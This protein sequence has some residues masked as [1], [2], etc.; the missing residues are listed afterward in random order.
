MFELR[1]Q[2]F[3]IIGIVIIATALYRANAIQVDTSLGKILGTT[4]KS[5]LGAD[6]YA[7]RGI[8]YAQSPEGELRFQNPKPYP[9][10]KPAILDAIEDGPMC[11]QV[12]ENVT[13]MSEDC[14]RLNVYT[15]DLNAKKPVV[16]YLHPGGFYSVSAQSKN[17]AG[18]EN[19]MDRD[20]VLVTLNYRL[21][22]LGFLAVG[23]AEAPGNAGLKDQVE[24]LRWI[25]SHISHFGGDPN[26]VTLFGY[27]AGSFSIGLHMM[28]PMSK[29][30]FHRGIMMSAS[31]LGQF[32][33]ESRQKRLS[34]RQAELLN[35]P[36]EPASDL[37]KCLKK[38][39]MMDFVTTSA[40][41]FDFNWNPILN[42]LPV[43]E[44]DFGQERFLVE[45]PYKTIQS[46]NFQKVPIIIGITEY[47]FVERAYYLQLN[48]TTKKWLNEEF[49]MYAPI[50]LLYERDTA[51]SKS[52]SKTLRSTYLGN[53]TLELPNTLDSFGKLYSDG[54]I[55]FEYHRFLDLL[56]RVTTVY[57]YLFTYKGRYS[58]FTYNNEVYGA[59]HHDELLYL[60]HVPVKTP[61]FKKTDPEN[62]V[63][64]NLTRMW[65]QFARTGDPNNATDEYLKDIKWPAYTNDKKPYLVIGNDLDVKEGGIFSQRFQIWDE[66]FPVPKF[67]KCH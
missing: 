36:K 25:Q 5:R 4:L 21:G 24:A 19:F 41:M 1:M 50:I 65:S 44:E 38:K 17:F 55:G 2:F 37:V 8:R 28:S 27:S 35:C 20:I 49:E 23:S 64:E 9:P 51:R 29:G 42:W 48:E 10:W 59:V 11:P 15:K 66:L 52:I 33:Y 32:D 45:N 60:L 16:V 18:P 40:Q 12:T 46:S 47:E 13:D 30:L 56:S 6:F 67:N 53:A 43:I 14:L 57:T 58:H 34:D 7:F 22:T 61:L 62:G 39:P 3:N 31:P 54:I 26:S 63:I